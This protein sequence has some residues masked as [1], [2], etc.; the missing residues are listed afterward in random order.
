[1]STEKDEH[2]HLLR[3]CE[4]FASIPDEA[5]E[6]IFELC[7]VE[8]YGPGSIMFRVDDPADKI[9]II[10][11]GVVEICRGGP[12]TP[13]T[14]TVAYLGEREC[15]GEMAI[16]S[17]CGQMQGPLPPEHVNCLCWRPT[18]ILE[19]GKRTLAESESRPFSEIFKERKK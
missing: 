6:R 12:D 10:E 1:M 4:L 5:L 9:Y 19:Q 2:L 14:N 3:N 11:S 16:C 8:T 7:T 17:R 15:L 18:F 13:S